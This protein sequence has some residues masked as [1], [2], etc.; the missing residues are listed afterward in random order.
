MCFNFVDLQTSNTF[1][2]W[3][4]W[5]WSKWWLNGTMMTPYSIDV[6]RKNL[7]LVMTY[8]VG[9]HNRFLWS[10]TLLHWLTLCLCV[11]GGWRWTRWRLADV[12]HMRMVV[13]MMMMML[14]VE[15]LP[16]WLLS[17][18]VMEFLCFWLLFFTNWCY[19]VRDFKVHKKWAIFV[20]FGF[21]F[22]ILVR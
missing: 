8:L 1:Y 19:N 7:N 15:F 17:V 3:R 14:V 6:I 13:M 12:W 21:V 16:V 4:R 20:L 22:F 9:N 2:W 5:W 11:V 10:W 18:F